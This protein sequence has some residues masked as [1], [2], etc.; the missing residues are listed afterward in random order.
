[1]NLLVVDW[2]GNG[3]ESILNLKKILGLI[4]YLGMFYKR[5]LDVY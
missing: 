5:V 4:N 3:I 1:M 2:K